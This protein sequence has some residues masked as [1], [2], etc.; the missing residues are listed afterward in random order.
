MQ[1]AYV[2]ENL[3]NA[4]HQWTETLGIGPWLL[5][6]HFEAENMTY[7]G[8]PTTVDLSVALAYAGSMC[9]ELVFVHNDVPNVY[10]DVVADH[11]Y[12]CFHHWAISTEE[13]DADVAKYQALGYDVSFYGE[14]VPVGGK[15]FAYIDTRVDN[16]GMIELIEMSQQV[17]GL[18]SMVKDLSKNW[19]G[20]CIIRRPE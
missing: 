20:E 6:E 16:G 8:E 5:L 2:V 11:G 12:G 18:F 9:Y 7:Y 17:Q 15:R 13:F 10:A 4:C 1:T 14:V 3:E 19:N